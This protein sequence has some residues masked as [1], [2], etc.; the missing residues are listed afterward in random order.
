MRKTLSALAFIL[1]F[2]LM[3]SAQQAHPEIPTVSASDLVAA[4]NAKNAPLVLQVGMAR[5]YRYAHIRGSEYVGQASQP[6]GLAGLRKRV[7][8]LPQSTASTGGVRSMPNESARQAEA[9]PALSTTR[10]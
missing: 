9:L 10:V 3:S 8:S 5:L 2:T 4:L 7:Q 1:T 6:E